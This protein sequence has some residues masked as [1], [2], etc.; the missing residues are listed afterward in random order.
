MK[1]IK[2]FSI[3]F[4]SIHLLSAQPAPGTVQKEP[5][6]ITGAEIHIGNGRTI[7]SGVLIFERGKISYVGEDVSKTNQ[8]QRV[9]DAKGKK[10]YP[11]FIAMASNLG[12]AEIEQVKATLDFR[13]FGTYNTNIRSLTSYNTDSKVIPTVRSNGVLMAQVA[14]QGG[15]ISGQSSVFQLDAW[16]WE[17]AVYAADEGIFIQWPN[18][19][20]IS[21]RVNAEV[22]AESSYQKE[23]KALRDYFD[24][25]KAYASEKAPTEV[26]LGYDGMRKLWTKEKTLFIRAGAPKAMI[27]AVQFAKEYNVEVVLVGAQGAGHI[28]SF[29]KEHRI[30]VVLAQTHR[31]PSHADEA[32]NMPYLLPK[33][34]Q[35]AGILF[36]LSMDGYWEQRNLAFQAGHCLAY[37]LSY[38]DALASISLNA[39]KIL[40]IDSRCGSIEPGKDATFFISDGDALDMKSQ[41]IIQ[42]FIQGREIDLDNKH[43]ELYRRFSGKPR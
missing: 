9:I 29:L 43:K 23:I 39:A 17:D 32:V 30:P 25:A 11:G 21:R 3:Y 14:P 38:Q 41:K 18:P 12:L 19:S 2:Y 15:I 20:G 10:L 27:H 16:N 37:G 35:E 22:S 36:C 42:A 33:I 7:V 26:H 31:L 34:L 13:E 4:F 5:I 24:L 1:F 28:L 40:R 8:I 6:A